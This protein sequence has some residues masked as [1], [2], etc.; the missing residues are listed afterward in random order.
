[1]S[2]TPSP[3]HPTPKSCLSP[4]PSPHIR[5]PSRRP[6][7]HELELARHEETAQVYWRTSV[8]TSWCGPA[9]PAFPGR[10]YIAPNSGA[11]MLAGIYVTHRAFAGLRRAAGL[12]ECERFVGPVAAVLVV[13][14]GV[15]GE[16]KAGASAV[17]EGST[18]RGPSLGLR[19]VL[20]QWR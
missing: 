9:T 15:E 3:S 16:G 12:K 6:C 19:W 14:V 2:T 20:V 8:V 18:P 1:M 10:L 4:R 11:C 7:D 13:V 5:P 17:E